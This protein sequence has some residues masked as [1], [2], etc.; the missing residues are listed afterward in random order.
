MGADG[1]LQNAALLMNAD[2][3]L[4]SLLNGLSYGLLLFLLSAGLTLIFS[5]LGVLNFAHAGFYMLGAYVAYALAGAMG[6]WPALVVAPLV[7]GGLGALLERFLLRRVHRMGHVPELLLTFGVLYLI[8]EIVQL[9][10][11]RS[12]VAL[13][14]PDTLQGSVFS[15][16]G[17]QFP[18]S[19][20]FI[21]GVS[22]LVLAGLWLVLARTRIG[23][24]IAAARTHPD[25][26]QALGHNVPRVF[27]GVFAGGCGL[28]GLAGVL[29][30]SVYVTEPGMAAS[31][32]SIVFV[33][34]VVGGVGSL[35]GAFLASLSIGV[36]QT[37]A[38]GLDVSL[39]SV[40]QALGMALTPQA[41]GEPVLVLTLA[42]LAPLLPYLLLVCMLLMRAQ[43]LM[44]TGSSA[45]K[46]MY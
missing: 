36:M 29:G 9:L 34:V 39:A 4:L 14:L 46:R 7:V 45:N 41:A 2:F 21:M 31:V 38:V 24:V 37:L 17:A 22:V 16:G 3:L 10:W 44:G 6:F 23:L 1:G 35:A 27:M 40:L 42:Q 26:V 5:L 18:R 13:T 30:G 25:M 43:G 15:L 20:A 32:G 28:A 8:V 11:G 19:R 33:V 12:S